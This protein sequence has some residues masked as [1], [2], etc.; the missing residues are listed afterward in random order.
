VQARLRGKKLSD[1][2]SA[3][4]LSRQSVADI[5]AGRVPHPRHFA[6]LASLVGVELRAG[7]DSR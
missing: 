7:Y 1:L 2:V 4:G 3:T 5:R 6:A